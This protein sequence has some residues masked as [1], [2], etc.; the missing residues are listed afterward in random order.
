MTKFF[1][2]SKCCCDF[3]LILI[4]FFFLSYPNN[5]SKIAHSLLGRIVAVLL[6]IYYTSHNIIYGLLFCL[7]ILLYYQYVP[8]YLFEKQE[9]F[10]WEIGKDNGNSPIYTPELLNGSEYK[11][12]DEEPLIQSRNKEDLDF[13]GKYCP[14]GDLKYKGFDVNPEMIEHVFPEI[15]QSNPCNPCNPM[16]KF[17]IVQS[18]LKT[19]D[20]IILPKSSNNWHDTI[21]KKIVGSPTSNIYAVEDL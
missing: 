21:M 11:P 15:K 17:S 14:L 1:D 3:S 2:Y 7:I 4:I 19:E 6:L 16:C 20:E 10:F 5:M 12:F 8:T 9:G 18:R 13:I